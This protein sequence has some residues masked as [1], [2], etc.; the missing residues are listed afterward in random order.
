M[1]T[2]SKLWLR[3]FA[4]TTLMLTTSM[5]LNAAQKVTVN[6]DIANGSVEVDKPN[7]TAGETVTITVTPDNGYYAQ[8]SNVTVEYTIDPGSANSPRLAPETGPAVGSKFN[9]TGDAVATSSD[10]A[11][12]TFVMPESP[13]CV[14]IDAEFKQCIEITSE[15]FNAI[16]DQE[17]VNRQIT[18]VPQISEAGNAVGLTS[19]DYDL[20]Y[21]ENFIHTGTVTI[22]A[23]GKFIGTVALNF[24]I[25]KPG[26]F[27]I[28][29]FN[30]WGPKNGGTENLPFTEQE[31]GT[32]VIEVTNWPVGVEFKV[33][34]D[35]YTTVWYGADQNGGVYN[36][37]KDKL[38]KAQALKT[39][40]DAANFGLPVPGDWTITV[41]VDYKYITITGTWKYAIN[42]P[43][44]ITGGTMT[45]TPNPAPAGETVTLTATPA[46]GYEISSL[47]VFTV[48]DQPS[49]IAVTNNTFT[50]PESD[51]NVWV[52]FTKIPTL[53]LRYTAD[54]WATTTDVQFTKDENGNWTLPEQSWPKNVAFKLIDENGDWYGANAAKQDGDEDYPLAKDM[55]GNELDLKTASNAKN[56]YMPVPGKWTITVNSLR[57]YMIVNGVWD[58]LITVEAPEDMNAAVKVQHYNSQEF[59][60]DTRAAE[61]EMVKVRYDFPVGSTVNVEVK[62]AEGNTVDYDPS[63]Y[64]FVMPYADVTVTVSYEISTYAIILHPVSGDMGYMLSTDQE[65]ISK[66]RPGTKVTVT[67]TPN[68]DNDFAA[69]GL[70][71]DPAVE[72]TEYYNG[73]YTFVMPS[74]NINVFAT[75]GAK[76]QGVEFTTDRHWATYMGKYTLEAPQGVSVYSPTIVSNGVVQVEE[77]DHIPDYEPVLL[78]SETPMSDITTAVIANQD[79]QSSTSHLL[80]SVDGTNIRK[81]DYVLYDDVFL[82][83]NED[84]PLA[85]HRCYIP[86]QA[87]NSSTTA[88][89]PRF[90]TIALPGQGG[91]VT[92]I[93]DINANDVASVKYV[94]MQGITSDKPFRGVNIMIITRTDGTTVN[95]K[96]VK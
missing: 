5:V 75:L 29:S 44:T 58:H 38:G 2:C 57:T 77:I 39:A 23:K 73:T 18:P 33:I 12:Y 79:E 46:E 7:A 76:L 48:G 22:R 92:G 61:G 60:E 90:L 20:T 71:T 36:I 49:E 51:V 35:E 65:D 62:D 84:G 81:G 91:T 86:A 72:V 11:H 50:M 40:S 82:R 42:I 70:V 41:S 26:L 17:W 87:V 19:N 31:D 83:V 6:T 54:N 9:P 93:E 95:R 34:N 25:V 85:A 67:V 88:G 89:A 27:L 47:Q 80:G 14:E 13:L 28:G 78:Y 64:C 16:P 30:N 43:E 94:N 59:V 96:V 24:N 63:T 15:M 37:D 10:P 1:K 45:A 69:V 55:I 3:V 4:L 32:Y 52:S 8:N 53:T 74:S 21:G 56:F 68:K 66:V